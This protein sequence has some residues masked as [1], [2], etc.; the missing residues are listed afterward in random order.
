M[1]SA[2]A[3]PHWIVRVINTRRT[4]APVFWRK[5]ILEIV[6][7]MKLEAMLSLGWF[8]ERHTHEAF[9]KYRLTQL[10]QFVPSAQLANRLVTEV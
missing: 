6:L 9:P 1:M 2:A 4:A 10:S 3:P 8:S 7:E 5:I